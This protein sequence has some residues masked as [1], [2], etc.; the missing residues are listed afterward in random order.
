MNEQ[1]FFKMALDW[2]KLIKQQSITRAEISR[3]EG[4]SQAR[5][6]QLM[7]LLKL[8]QKVQRGLLAGVPEY[9]GWT[10][11]RGLREGSLI[12]LGT[13]SSFDPF[14]RR[15]SCFLDI[16]SARCTGRNPTP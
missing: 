15:I 2:Q 12:N 1:G 7:S 14:R 6:T 3:R 4:L 5:V 13:P 8:P 9:A 11:R 16:Q 10:V